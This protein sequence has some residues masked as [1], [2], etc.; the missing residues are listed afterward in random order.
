MAPGAGD[1][2]VGL[3]ACAATPQGPPG[4]PS[5]L[6]L[7]LPY[8]SLRR[9]CLGDKCKDNRNLSFNR[10]HLLAGI[11]EERHACWASGEGSSSL[12]CHPQLWELVLCF[13][14]AL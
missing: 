12:V 1:S 2:G 9:T 8:S 5:N 10:Q 7:R 4:L 14:R 6:R 3:L 13:V 11:W